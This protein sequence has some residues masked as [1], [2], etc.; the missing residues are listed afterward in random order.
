M[1]D[2]SEA[3]LAGH[4]YL[5]EWLTMPGPAPLDLQDIDT[6]DRVIP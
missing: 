5:S 4:T 3:V 6:A 1:Q 2:V